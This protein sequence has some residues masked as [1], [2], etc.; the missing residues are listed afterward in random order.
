MQSSTVLR[1]LTGAVG[2]GKNINIVIID[3][4][5]QSNFILNLGIEIYCT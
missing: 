1:D 3:L 4:S 2:P 5:R